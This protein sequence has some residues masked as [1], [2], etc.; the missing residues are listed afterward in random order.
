MINIEIISV[1][2]DLLLDSNLTLLTLYMACFIDLLKNFHVSMISIISH[3]GII[4]EM[5]V[6]SKV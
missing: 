5:N 3:L 2:I 6:I 4:Y 1:K